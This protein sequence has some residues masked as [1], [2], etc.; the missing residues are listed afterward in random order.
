MVEMSESLVVVEIKTNGVFL[1][2]SREVALLEFREGAWSESS[3]I[4]SY[5]VSRKESQSK[6]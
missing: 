6:K 4:H 3:S 5:Y 2:K 1:I